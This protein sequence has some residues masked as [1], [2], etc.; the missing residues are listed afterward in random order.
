MAFFPPIPLIRKKLIIKKLTKCNAFT[1]NTAVTFKEAGIINPNG[2]KKIT[3]KL[4]DQELLVKTKDNKYYLNKQEERISVIGIIIYAL[5]AM[6]FFAYLKT[7]EA[8]FMLYGGVLLIVAS[9]MVML[10]KSK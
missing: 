3:K 9:I 4:I 2:F 1:E 10:Y 5:A 6:C 8:E 7:R